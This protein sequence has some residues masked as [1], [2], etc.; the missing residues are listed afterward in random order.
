VPILSPALV[1][2]AI[3]FEIHLL[4]LPIAPGQKNKKSYKCPYPA[5]PLSHKVPQYSQCVLDIV[6]ELFADF[7]LSQKFRQFCLSPSGVA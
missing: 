1:S 7:Q 2:F 4:L 5:E 3:S 6:Q